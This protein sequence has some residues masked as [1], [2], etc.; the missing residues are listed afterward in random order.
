MPYRATART[1]ASAAGLAALLALTACGSDY[2]L[3]EEQRR[4]AEANSSDLSGTLTGVGSSAQGAAMSAWIADFTSLN[5]DVNIQYS[6]AG[7]GAGRAAFLAGGVAF[8]GSDAFLG[9]AQMEEA[10][11]FCGP[12]GAVNVPT[13]IAPIALAF[14]LPGIR[15]V[16]LDPE[17]IAKIFSGEITHWQDPAIA[18]L[19]DGV[20]LPDLRV[21]AVHRADDSGTTENFTEYLH[22]TAPN[23]WPHDPSGSWPAAVAGENAQGNAGVMST[24]TRT[25]GAIGYVDDSVVGRDS[26]KAR[27][28]V[29]DGFVAVGADA[30]GR[31]VAASSPAPGRGE[32]DFALHLDRT[33]TAEGAYPLVLVSYQ[34][35]C[36]SYEDA[37]MAE[38]AR[39]FGLHALSADGQQIAAEAAGSAPVPRELAQRA[40]AVLETIHAR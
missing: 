31:A 1:T 32:E 4:A 5:P 28:K 36:R 21:S 10:T 15:E 20:E 37:E 23:H 14:N 9:E 39:E 18:A 2:P 35:F 26:G 8:A 17:T 27:I 16:D 19:N 6:P 30:A 3:G 24:I 40:S 11:G 34:I 33:T 13:Y 7:S 38:L 22:E 29:G 25:A 12:D